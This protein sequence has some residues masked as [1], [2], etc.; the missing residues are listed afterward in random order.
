MKILK[1]VIYLF[2]IIGGLF[3]INQRVNVFPLNDYLQYWSAVQINLARQNPYDADQMYAIQLTQGWQAPSAI[4]MWNPPMTIGLMLPF[5]ILPY[6]ISRLA[7]FFFSIIVAL[8]VG[9]QTWQIYGGPNSVR[10]LGILLVITFGPMLQL[11]KLGQIDTWGLIGIIG[12]LLFIRRKDYFFAG[13]MASLTLVKPHMVYLFWMAL[14]FWTI[15][16][17][18]WTIWIGVSIGLMIPLAIAWVTNPN[19]VNQYLYAMTT[20]PPQQWIT[21]T[22]GSRL[23]LIFGPEYFYLQFLPTILGGLIFII[24]FAKRYRSWTWEQ[25]LPG[26]ILGSIATASY[27]WI[28]DISLGVVAV[29]ALGAVIA[30][31]MK[32][33]FSLNSLP[34]PVIVLSI[35]YL[36][37]SFSLGFISAQYHELWMAGSA[38][39]LLYLCFQIWIPVKAFEAG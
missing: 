12:F 31:R 17:R 10:W 15:V 25:E 35:L 34:K 22:I 20:S 28:F 24:Y 13:L 38:I 33:H 16:K 23:R 3:F 39:F 21:A 26:V 29:I 37:I 1:I 18:S 2:I 19:V 14:F 32:K 11:F 5:G 30:L 27:G 6:S 4:M 9:D 8:L 7:Y 36:V